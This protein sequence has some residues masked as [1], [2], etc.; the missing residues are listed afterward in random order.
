MNEN[1]SGVS[2]PSRGTCAFGPLTVGG[3]ARRQIPSQTPLGE[4]VPS[5]WLATATV[6]HGSPSQTPLGE[7]VPSAIYDAMYEA[8]MTD[9]SQTPLGER[10]P[11]ARAGAD[12]GWKRPPVSNPSRGTCAFGHLKPLAANY[13]CELSQTPLG[14]RVPS[15]EQDAD[16][17][18]VSVIESQTPLGERVPSATLCASRRLMRLSRSQTPLGERVPSAAQQTACKIG[19]ACCLKPL[20]GNVC[21]R[22]KGDWVHEQSA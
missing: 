15:A 4:R 16:T 5:A 2:N 13:A 22:P 19:R 9:V 1:E 14:E 7:R 11:S 3:N 6:R 17:G 12:G 18:R 20:S 21:L 8:A 10:V